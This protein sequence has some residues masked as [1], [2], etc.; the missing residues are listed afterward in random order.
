MEANLGL[1]LLL[2][3]ISAFFS[4]SE[5]AFLAVGDTRLRYLSEEGSRLARLLIFLRQHRTWVL[6]TVL[7]AITASNYTAERLATQLSIDYISPTIGPIIACVA[8]TTVV[9]IFCEV[10]PIQYAARHSETMAIRA[11][12]PIT[13]FAVLLAP[14][15][16][17]L[18]TI[19]RGL[20][21]VV[22]CRRQAI[23]PPVTEDQL[24]AMI[25][26][27][28]QQGV[29]PAVQRRM[30]YGALDFGDQTVA[31][32]MKPRPDIVWVDLDSTL[33]RVL[34]VGTQ[35]GF[36]RLPVAEEDLDDV[37]GIIHLKD[38]LPYLRKG[39]MDKPVRLVT[40]AAMFVPE[41]LPAN[42]LLRQ[43]QANHRTIAIAKDEFGGTAGLVTVED[44]LEEIVGEI[45]DEYD[46]EQPPIQPQSERE[47]LCDAR[48][49]L[50]LLA[51]YVLEELPETEYD[52][53]GG[54][55]LDIAGY[56]PTEGDQV[57]WR[58]LEF[59][60]EQISDNRIEQ[61]R[62]VQQPPGSNE[63]TAG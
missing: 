5:V 31:Q 20:L 34:E 33:Q 14:V 3:G 10:T 37:V 32:V 8:I 53:L 52:S 57:S 15:I 63:D 38:I 23:L 6:S 44:L 35:A 22:G 58:S 4:G 28:E 62:V 59:T 43:L 27:G 41:S 45:S 19:V 18:T 2:L 60:I 26:Q 16:L 49:S 61:V 39:E 50:H 9:L 46:S 12:G 29:V 54:L 42:V 7:I 24:K 56:I 13:I 30:L 36:S 21:F 17:V 11:A 47:F 25:E 55:I 51:N 40:R 1:I 48:I